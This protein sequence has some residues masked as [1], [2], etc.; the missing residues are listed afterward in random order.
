MNFL[1]SGQKGQF[2][3]KYQNMQIRVHTVT[4][5]QMY[6]EFYKLLWALNFLRATLKLKNVFFDENQFI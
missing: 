3:T 2:H 1:Q 6:N 4:Y 5:S